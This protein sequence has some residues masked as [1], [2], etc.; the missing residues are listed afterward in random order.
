MAKGLK[1]IAAA[2]GNIDPKVYKAGAIITDK[3][4]GDSVGGA[5]AQ[6]ASLDGWRA[7]NKKFDK[8][9]EANAPNPITKETDITKS[10]NDATKGG[11]IT[12]SKNKN[13]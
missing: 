5:G 11:G 3:L 12:L 8:N 9:T 4:A 13:K 7:N 6:L 2:L 1:G 10:V